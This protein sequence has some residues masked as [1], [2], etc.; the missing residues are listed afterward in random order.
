MAVEFRCEKCGKLLSVEAEPNAKVKCPYCKGKVTVP[1]G[2]AAMPRPQVPP[3][4]SAPAPVQAAPAP[5]PEEPVGAEE[6]DALMG[7]MAAVMPWL[8]S[9]FFH[10]GLVVILWFVLIVALGGEQAEAQ[11]IVPSA[12]LSETPGGQIEPGQDDP[13]MEARSLERIQQNKW[14]QR[15]STLPSTSV[16]ETESKVSVIG[17]SGGSAGGS[18]AAFGLTTGG[19]G[20]GPKSR[21]FGT[22]GNAYHIVYV[23]D[24]SGSM[25]DTLDLVRR[26]MLRSVSRLNEAQTFHVIFFAT[27][28][29]KENPPRRLVYAT[30]ENKREAADYLKSIQAQGRTDPIPAL[31]RAFQ[32]LQRTPNDRTGK[33]IYLLTDGEFPDNEKV[34]TTIRGLN[35]QGDVHI[36]TILH[37]HRSPPV[38]KVL[39]A[40]ARENGGR[41]KFV[42][43]NQ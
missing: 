38:M 32:V 39:Q 37:Y 30:I 42:E 14:A 8:I 16:G 3:G 21:F 6:P 31:T 34:L 18:A 23:V 19:S 20:V 5:P 27:G 13:D 29:P 10:L 22:G 24:R 7:V 40:I 25:L 36:N 12:E 4:A 1:A 35:K 9:V 17:I 28:T 33:L 2:L 41:F 11:A 43:P 15:D 26:E